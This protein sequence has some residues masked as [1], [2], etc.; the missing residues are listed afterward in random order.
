MALKMLEDDGYTRYLYVSEKSNST[1][2]VCMAH[3]GEIH[4]RIEIEQIDLLP[5]LHPNCRCSL[6]AMDQVTERLYNADK[7]NLLDII[8]EKLYNFNERI[9]VLNPDMNLSFVPEL[10]LGSSVIGTDQS[11]SEFLEMLNKWVIGFGEDA[12]AAWDA[13]YAEAYARSDKKFDRILNFLDWITA[14]I[15]SGFIDGLFERGNRVTE[16]PSLY[17]IVNWILI[18]IPDIF[19]NALNPDK[20]F[21]FD[22]WMSSLTAVSL[23]VGG[24]NIIKNRIYMN[25]VPKAQLNQRLLDELAD[26][27]VKYNPDD[28]V[29]ITK[30]TKGKLVWLESGNDTA[31]FNHIIK[32][33]ATDFANKG[34][35]QTD[36]PRY[37]SQAL[38]EGKIVG[39]QGRGI[40]RPIY[41]FTY[42]GALQRVAITVGNNGFIVGANP[43]S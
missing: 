20:P 40:G 21:S 41:E 7:S 12:K 9:Y 30:T 10:S 4:S 43:V 13:F 26:S 16:D 17:N 34:I 25:Q 33:H 3:H 18:G 27:G 5:P 23:L 36:I 39:Y 6:V 15:V 32:E 38:N 2:S 11:L 31:G 42:N 22:H 24:Y 28:V 8:Q 1:C 14:G 19:K 37:I 35:L 29:M